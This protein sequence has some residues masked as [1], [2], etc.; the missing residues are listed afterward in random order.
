MKHHLALDG[1][2]HQIFSEHLI[3][4]ICLLTIVTMEKCEVALSSSLGI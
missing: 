4:I 2:K 1:K 3:E